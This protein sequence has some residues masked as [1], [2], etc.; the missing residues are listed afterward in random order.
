M[1]DD[2]DFGGQFWHF[3]LKAFLAKLLC[4]IIL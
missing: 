3:G 1:V 4:Q 2:R